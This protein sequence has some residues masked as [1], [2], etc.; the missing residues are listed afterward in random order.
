MAVAADLDMDAGH[1]RLGQIGRHDA[2][3][4][5]V[6]GEWRLQH[7]AIAQRHQIRLPGRIGGA[8]DADRVRPLRMRPPAGMR[9]A[10]HAVAQPF[11]GG[12]PV[13]GL[14][15]RWARFRLGVGDCHRF[16]HSTS[17]VPRL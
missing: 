13:R 1:R 7:A 8:Q 14:Y 17:S 16:L 6:K 10:R 15:W 11:A 12:P 5:A 4:P 9:I 3:G 2:G